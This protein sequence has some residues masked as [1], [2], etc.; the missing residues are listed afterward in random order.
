MEY[1]YSTSYNSTATEGEA[2]AVLGIIFLIFGIF[3]IFY[4]FTA[5]CLSKIF[6]KAGITPWHAW[7]PV[8]N[9]WKFLEMGNQ[10]G[11]LALLSLIPPANLALPIFMLIATYRINGKFGKDPVLYLILYLLVSP[12]W[13]VMLAFGDA[14][15]NGQQAQQ[16]SQGLPKLDNQGSGQSLS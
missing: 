8:L 6:K 14:K 5:I 11:A 9:S 4:I 2:L 13:Y 7:V 12:V 3:L 16:D 1:S 10:N 15:W